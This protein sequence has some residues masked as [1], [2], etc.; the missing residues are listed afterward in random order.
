MTN[1]QI[2]RD[3]ILQKWYG[4]NTSVF[5]RRLAGPI[6]QSDYLGVRVPVNLPFRP[7][8]CCLVWKYALNKDGYGTLT[9]V[10]DKLAHRQAF[11][12][13]HGQIPEGKQINHLCNRPYCIQ[14]SH[15]YAGDPQDNADDRR[16][17][18]DPESFY[19]LMAWHFHPEAE[20]QDPE[21]KRLRDSDRLET[22]EPWE[23]PDQPPQEPLIEFECPGHDFQ[24][25]MQGNDNKI[26]RICEISEGQIETED[27]FQTYFLA[28][29]FCPA[30]QSVLP[31]FQAF[32]DSQFTRPSQA[33]FREK[34]YNRSG[35]VGGDHHDIRVCQ[36]RF[37][38]QDQKTFRDLL[39][40][41]L[42]NQQSPILDSC[43]K[44]ALPA[45]Q[46]L[47]EST[48]DVLEISV[49]E[50][51]PT[52]E[53]ITAIR[54]HCDDCFNFEIRDNARGLEMTL[55]YTLYAMT[56]YHNMKEM[57]DENAFYILPSPY[58]MFEGPW[59]ITKWDAE[60]AERLKDLIHSTSQNMITEAQ[61]AAE[62]FTMNLYGPHKPEIHQQ[63]WEIGSIF[64]RAAVIEHMRYQFTGRNSSTQSAPPHVDC[65]RNILQKES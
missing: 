55:A 14:P 8:G 64:I 21:M 42:T 9:R 29:E 12:Q 43:D 19:K 13:A 30:S 6:K 10:Q 51:K 28:R 20:F 27:Q 31:I 11:I 65:A 39:Q 54:D 36:C 25:R 61:R 34:A 60:Q 16:I 45:R 33:N 38:E 7:W 4:L 63:I 47:L 52:P 49:Q 50:A 5:G 35:R 15:L 59:R 17:F 46:I 56:Q 37:C 18:N 26:C 3:A 1:F 57:E 24:I 32:V 22:A 44:F 58:R 2:E 62:G 53:Q 23:P 48:K 41:N 40:P